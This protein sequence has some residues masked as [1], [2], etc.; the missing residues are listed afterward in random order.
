MFILRQVIKTGGYAR[1]RFK[2][3]KLLVARVQERFVE[4]VVEELRGLE[5]P[6]YLFF[7]G[8]L[9]IRSVY[10]VPGRAVRE[11]APYRSAGRLGGVGRPYDQPSDFDGFLALDHDRDYRLRGY[12]LL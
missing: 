6:V 2:R 7:S 5:E 4:L 3:R 11:V 8:L 12:E 9:R 1:K 10:H